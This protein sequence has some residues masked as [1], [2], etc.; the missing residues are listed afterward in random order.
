[1]KRQGKGM[2]MMRIDVSLPPRV[3]VITRLQFLLIDFI[4]KHPHDP[5]SDLSSFYGLRSSELRFNAKECKLQRKGRT[6]FRGEATAI[7]GDVSK[8]AQVF[9][10]L[11]N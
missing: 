1:M 11:K 3:N 6:P 2:T 8:T 7:E 5:L 4:R 9:L 10:F